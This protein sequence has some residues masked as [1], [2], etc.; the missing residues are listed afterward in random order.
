MSLTKPELDIIKAAG[1]SLAKP[2]LD[3]V[4]VAGASFRDCFIVGA[5]EKDNIV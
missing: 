5:I 1:T 4:Q 3:I 2:E